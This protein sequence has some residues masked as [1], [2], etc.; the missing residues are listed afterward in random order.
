[1]F[2]NDEGLVVTAFPPNDLEVCDDDNDGF[3]VF[4]LTQND[5][6]IL[7]GQPNVTVTYHI[8]LADAEQGV[9]SIGNS[10]SYQNTIPFQQT[11]YARTQGTGIGNYDVVSFDL[12]VNQSPDLP[13]P[14]SNI[15]QCGNSV[16]D[17]SVR[18]SEIF[19]NLSPS[20][21]ILGYFISENDAVTND[22][23][24]ID[25]NSYQA[26]SKTQII[27]ARLTNLA[28][29]CFNTTYFQIINGEADISI[30]PSDLFE[31]SSTP[32]YAIFD[33]TQNTSVVLNGDDPSEYDV[34]YFESQPD[35]QQNL[36]AIAVPEAYTNK[37]NPQ[38]VYVRKTN[39]KSQCF[40]VS[41]FSI[42]ADATVGI[43]D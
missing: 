32:G 23:G 10:Q 5:S 18:D 40:A 35:T 22:N 11:I 4:D 8:T 13:T 2:L 39:L 28:T 31:T 6:V 20:D 34:A 25:L 1:V 19:G 26:I 36:N 42:Q 37:T 7:N 29:G 43:A 15:V 27:Y 30:A 24:I 14:V 16:F 33:L 38:T 41:Q 9:N 17:L 3:A 21:Y 12:I